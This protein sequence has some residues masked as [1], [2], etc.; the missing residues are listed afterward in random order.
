M[1][2]LLKFHRLTKEMKISE[3]AK[4]AKVSVSL[5]SRIESGKSR[6]S[7]RTRTKISTILEI[8]EKILFGAK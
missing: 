6:G 4:R 8:P 7:K 1:L 3:L 5:L 2:T